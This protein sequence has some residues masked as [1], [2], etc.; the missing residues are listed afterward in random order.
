MRAR[1]VCITSKYY[2]YYDIALW[3]SDV[4]LIPIMRTS[5]PVGPRLW[6]WTQLNEVPS[7]GAAKL[8]IGPTSTPRH[9]VTI[10]SLH[11]I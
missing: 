6:T 9:A 3:Q 8:A 4:G 5:S 1:Q 2:Y 10:A 11:S 7:A